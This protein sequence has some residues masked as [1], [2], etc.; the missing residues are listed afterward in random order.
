MDSPILPI[1]SSPVTNLSQSKAEKPNKKRIRP[2]QRTKLNPL[3]RVISNNHREDEVR[4]RPDWMTVSG[5][6][7]SEV[8]KDI[9]NDWT[10]RPP[11]HGTEI[12]KRSTHGYKSRLQVEEDIN[13]EQ[14]RAVRNSTTLPYFDIESIPAEDREKFAERRFELPT[15]DALE[16][17][18]YSASQFCRD[19]PKGHLLQ[20]K[21]LPSI[22]MALGMCSLL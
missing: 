20:E 1:N 5:E 22:L 3:R 15:N 18:H 11:N 9:L 10:G 6:P 8:L 16:A 2:H 17:I 4:L 19:H 7:S 14:I 12:P 13:L 21:M